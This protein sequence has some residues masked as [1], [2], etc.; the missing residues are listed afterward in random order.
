MNFIIDFPPLL[1][2]EKIYDSILIVIDRYSRMIQFIFC[3]KDI[4]VPELAE[5]IGKSVKVLRA[6]LRILS[7]KMMPTFP[8]PCPPNP[9]VLSGTTKIPNA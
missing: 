3:N 2:R 5:I 7:L 6:A 1:F 9:C 8:S 4:D